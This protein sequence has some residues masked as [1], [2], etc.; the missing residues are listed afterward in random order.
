M[1]YH[2]FPM[3]KSDYIHP[4]QIRFSRAE[5]DKYMGQAER[6]GYHDLAP[7]IRHTLNMAIRKFGKIPN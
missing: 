2:R 6:E 7:W 5:K 1:K 3:N 4:Y